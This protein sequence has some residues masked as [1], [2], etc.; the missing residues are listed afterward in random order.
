MVQ[1]N[2][3]SSTE[4]KLDN[5]NLSNQDFLIENYLALNFSPPNQS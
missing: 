2:N 5:I 4:Y 3:I 1:Y